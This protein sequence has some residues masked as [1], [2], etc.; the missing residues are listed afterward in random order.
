MDSQWTSEVETGRRMNDTDLNRD[1]LREQREAYA[2]GALAA[3]DR[4]ALATRLAYVAPAAEP[5]RDC[6]T[7]CFTC[8]KR[9]EA[10]FGPA[11]QGC[12]F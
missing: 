9:F 12:L 8:F 10:N 3:D 5:A 2:L 4:A 11:N 7:V 6:A 1:P